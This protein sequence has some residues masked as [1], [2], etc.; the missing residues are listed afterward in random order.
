MQQQKVG[1]SSFRKDDDAPP[2]LQPLPCLQSL[3]TRHA[4]CFHSG[5]TDNLHVLAL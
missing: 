2:L 5:K 3:Q 4:C 1:F